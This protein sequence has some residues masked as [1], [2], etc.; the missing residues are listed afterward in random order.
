MTSKTVELMNKKRKNL[1]VRFVTFKSLSRSS[2]EE[3]HFDPE[4]S[5]PLI[6]VR[7]SNLGNSVIK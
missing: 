6:E 1:R 7:D 5:A 3:E 4:L 2:N